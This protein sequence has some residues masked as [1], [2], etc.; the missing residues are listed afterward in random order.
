M[1]I[2]NDMHFGTQLNKHR[3]RR[4]LTQTE[5][6]GLSAVSI[7]AIRNLEQGKVGLPRRDTVRLLADALRLTAEERVSFN[8]A[9]ASQG[10]AAPFEASLPP[11]AALPLRGRSA[12]LA[13][14]LRHLTAPHG[15]IVSITGFWGAGKS[16]LAAA[17]AQVLRDRENT[18][19]FWLSRGTEPETDVAQLAELVTDRPALLVLDGMERQ[20]THEAGW[21]LLREC[22]R[23]RILRTS[24]TE[25]GE[26]QLALAPLPVPVRRDPAAAAD[27]P[28]LQLLVDLVPDLSSPDAL[29]KRALEALSVVCRGLD[30]LPG[31]L[32]SAAGWS[33]IVGLDQLAEMARTEPELLAAHPGGGE[34]PESAVLTT[35]G[36]L[37]AV[38]RELLAALA[39]AP[40]GWTVYEAAQRL[41]VPRSQL[42]GAVHAFRQLGLIRPAAEAPGQPGF[43]VLHLVRRFLQPAGQREPAATVDRIQS[44]PRTAEPALALALSSAASKNGIS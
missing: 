38:H 9:A 28:A 22:P 42:A 12:E 15:R 35:L 40:G 21:S 34:D 13:T 27:S 32:T 4:H 18:L 19:V 6:S 10:E 41:D 31:A 2:A 5:L 44:M 37:P 14:V 8:L 26:L 16:R 3:K 1:T 17:A 39:C 36:A 20:V 24:R 33:E 23:L 43:T 11:M 29:D 25:G 30:G 7:R